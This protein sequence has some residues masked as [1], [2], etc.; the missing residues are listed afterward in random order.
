MCN[1]IMFG[2]GGGGGGGSNYVYKESRRTGDSFTTACS[3]SFFADTEIPSLTLEFSL[4]Q[5]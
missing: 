4:Q 2:W 1:I 5:S 3:S